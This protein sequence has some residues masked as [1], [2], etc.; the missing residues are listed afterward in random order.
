MREGS[1]AE[2][3]KG[4]RVLGRDGQTIGGVD[5]VLVDEGSGIFVGL[6]VRP[7][8]FTHPLRVPG[9]LVDRVHGAVVHVDAVQ[10]ELKSYDT[11]AEKHYQ[12]EQAY[13]EASNT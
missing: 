9:E 8:M 1:Y 7:S 12:A 3:Q 4:M 10:D 5:E 11:P 13:T 6:S 2:I